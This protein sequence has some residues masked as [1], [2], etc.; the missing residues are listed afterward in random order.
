MKPKKLFSV[1]D[2]RGALCAVEARKDVPFQIRRIFYIYEN[3]DCLNRG[4]HAHYE[5]KQFLICLKG[6]CTVQLKD[7]QGNVT[8]SILNSPDIGLF[9]DKLVWGEMYDFS[10]DCIM[11]VLASLE[12]RESDYI[13]SR[14]DFAAL[15]ETHGI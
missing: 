7:L 9:Q 2:S 14:K 12:Y 10:A 5:T 13:R 1:K 8:T 15:A 6:S 3:L 4:Y 11:L